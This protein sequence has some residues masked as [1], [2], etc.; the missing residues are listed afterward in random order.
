[1]HA[2]GFVEVEV[3]FYGLLIKFILK[4]VYPLEHVSLFDEDR[5]QD[6][7]PRPVLVQ[8]SL[9]RV[10]VNNGLLHLVHESVLLQEDTQVIVYREVDVVDD[11]EP[12]VKL[13]LG[14]KACTR[15]DGVVFYAAFAFE[16]RK[17]I[18]G[19]AQCPPCEGVGVPVV[20]DVVF[21]LIGTGDTEDDI[22]VLLL[23]PVAA[24]SPETRD[25]DEPPP[26]RIQPGN[27][28]R[29]YAVYS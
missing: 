14:V 11:L 21:V 15:K 19:V 3:A 24:A 12:E 16:P 18:D 7:V 29:R 27:P 25:R 4:E 5:P 8:R 20:V 26:A 22:L 13:T 28:G 6:A 17:R 1:M 2:P 23:R 9:R 10:K